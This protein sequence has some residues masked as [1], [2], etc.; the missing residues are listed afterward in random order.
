LRNHGKIAMSPINVL[1]LIDHVC[2]DG[3]LHGGGRL[4]WTILPRFD[5]T[6]LR[7]VPCFLRASDAVRE[8]FR[9]S[10]TP[11]RILDKGKY[12]LTT[13]WTILKIIREEKIQVMHLHCYAA[14]TFG[15]IASLLT[16]V[17]AIIHDYDTQIYFPYPWYLAAADKALSPATRGAVAASPMVRDYMV[18]TRS[19]R[20]DKIRMMF[21]AVPLDKYSRVR[22]AEENAGTKERLGIR[23]DAKVVGAITKLGPKR[24]ND[25]L[26]R[27]AAEVLKTLPDAVFLLV[28]KPT[29]YHRIPKEFEE[30]KDKLHDTDAMKTE[31][32]DL[33]RRLNIEKNVVFVESLDKPDE[34]ASICDVVVAPFLDDR[35]SSVNLIEAM[36]MGKPVI[37]TDLGEQRE[38]VK[39]GV[40]GYLVAPGDEKDLAGKIVSTLS[41]SEALARMSR[42]AAEDARQYSAEAYARNLENWY[43]EF[44]AP[45]ARA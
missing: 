42:Q 6:R 11:V 17:P 20:A 4:Y 19:V 14:S 40:N 29:Y 45:A 18:K 15:R 34:Y 27:A 24:G 30:M 13:L 33:A 36:A 10:P 37:A 23:P 38:I 28:Y 26:L 3:S 1:W 5:A 35:F 22:P 7:V 41:N 43:T 2:Y 44:A 12:D 32:V 39:N 21:H 16:G 9:N 8:V 31:L 25:F